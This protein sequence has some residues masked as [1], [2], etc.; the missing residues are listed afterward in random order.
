[1]TT[2]GKDPLDAKTV[3]PVIRV[4]EMVIDDLPKVFHMGEELFQPEKV[5]NTYRT[6]DEYEVIELFRGDAEFCFVAEMNRELVGFALGTTITKTHSAWKYG[7]LVWLGVAPGFQRMGV[8]EKLFSRFREVMLKHRVRMLLVDTETENLPA[9]RLFRKLGF[10]HPQE[11]IYLTMNLGSK[12]PAGKKRPNGEKKDR[13]PGEGN[14]G[15]E[16]LGH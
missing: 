9:L 8:A 5:P 13:R 2:N 4:R 1:M 14:H 7:H 15:D 16:S 10:K 3:R 11:H 12:P 6:W